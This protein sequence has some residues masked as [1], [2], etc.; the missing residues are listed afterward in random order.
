MCP[1]QLFAALSAW[2]MCAISFNRWYSVCRPSSYF[3][4]TSKTTN[5]AAGKACGLASSNGCETSR[6]EKQAPSTPFAFLLNF[7]CLKHNRKFRDHLHA[8]RSI[9]C[10]TLMGI[11][12]CLYPIFMHELR[13]I[14]PVDGPIF[15]RNHKLTR[16]TAVVLKRCNYSQK[17]EYAYDFI[18]IILSCLLHILPL[19]FVAAMNLMII[20]R[21]KQRQR[22]MSAS[23]G[24]LPSQK[25]KPAS[26]HSE[27]SILSACKYP[28]EKLDRHQHH[29]K[30]SHQKIRQQ[31]TGSAT[32]KMVTHKDQGTST[33]LPVPTSTP[34]NQNLTV[35]IKA[36]AAKRHHSRDRTITIML[37]SVAL[38]YL[39]LTLPYRLFWLYNV[40]TKRMHPEKLKS[41][42][43]LLK[44]HYIDHVLRTIRNIHYGTNFLFFIFL[45]KTFRR[46]FRQIFIEKL[47]RAKHDTMP[48]HSTSSLS[49]HSTH[50]KA[51]RQ[52]RSTSR[53]S[54]RT[55]DPNRRMINDDRSIGI[56]NLSRSVFDEIPSFVAD[57]RPHEK[58][59]IVP[60]LELEHHAL[61]RYGGE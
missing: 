34:L 54:R 30:R 44:M 43:F 61:T 60:I 20:V 7:S 23:S 27:R 42:I 56:D 47:F 16:T 25:K 39:I 5:G 14:N 45:S 13:P 4:R 15:D 38:S 9:G 19:T 53:A 26:P 17:H 29:H 55:K 51:H 18:G 58:E 59:E 41:S 24:I 2:Y 6:T 57:A 31:S 35:P 46:R 11:L 12:S 1:D 52:R 28:L 8:F 21:L 10:I 40:Y 49:N 48:R 37:V 33:D 50:V 36:T 22:L 32:I 3:F